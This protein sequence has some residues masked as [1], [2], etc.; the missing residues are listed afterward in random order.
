M[1]LISCIIIT[2]IVGNRAAI[3]YPENPRKV[4]NTSITAAGKSTVPTPQPT[5]LSNSKVSSANGQQTSAQKS[6]SESPSNEK[7]QSGASDVELILNQNTTH[8]VKGE[9]LSPGNSTVEKAALR[10]ISITE[11]KNSFSSS[12]W[13]YITLGVLCV[14][15][16]N[17]YIF[18]YRKRAAT[19]S[20]QPTG[21]AQR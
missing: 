3:Q 2:L 14:A 6:N 18:W 4:N 20:F 10:S 5:G 11:E 8:G 16:F 13:I 1:K 19:Y 15:V 7:L 21:A 17:V 12:V 9:A